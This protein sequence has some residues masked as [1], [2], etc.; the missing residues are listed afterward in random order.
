MSLSLSPGRVNIEI[1][2]QW[3]K[4]HFKL[5]ILFNR[6]LSD[7][8]SGEGPHAPPRQRG[9]SGQRQ[10]SGSPSPSGLQQAP[11]TLSS[12]PQGTKQ[13][14][15]GLPPTPKVHMGACFS[16]VRRKSRTAST[17]VARLDPHKRK[18]PHKPT[19]HCQLRKCVQYLLKLK[20]SN[21]N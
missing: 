6:S 8:R 11:S 12:E 15:N 2:Q 19:V 14:S 18:L 7:S 1:W 17:F 10:S 5:A 4:I 9:R 13:A 21:T 3:H 20:D 16:K